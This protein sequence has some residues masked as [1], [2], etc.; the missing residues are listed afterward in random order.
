MHI[1]LLL[2]VFSFTSICSAQLKPCYNANGDPIA[3]I[4]CDP[5]ANVS[6]CCFLGGSC[7]TNFYC[8]GAG[9]DTFERVG[10][11]TDKTG[12]DPACP[13]PF[14]RGILPSCH[15]SALP[16]E[17]VGFANSMATQTLMRGTFLITN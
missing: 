1:Y 14:L 7:E 11:C 6:T 9:N 16:G 5:S 10:G 4:P 3:Q 17:R 2:P 13:F 15:L 12:S 8:H